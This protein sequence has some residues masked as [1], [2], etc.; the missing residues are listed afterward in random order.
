MSPIRGLEP[1]AV[2]LSPFGARQNRADWRQGR[3]GLRT[4]I[5]SCDATEPL[6][7]TDELVGRRRL[8]NLGSNAERKGI[9][10]ANLKAKAVVHDNLI[11]FRDAWAV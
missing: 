7:G 10:S 8:V 4:A 1:S 3:S 6:I 11:H 2:P 5:P 9:E